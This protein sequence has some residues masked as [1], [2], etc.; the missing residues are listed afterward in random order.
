[1]KVFITSGPIEQG[2]MFVDAVLEVKR[3]KLFPFLAGREA[4]RN[5]ICRLFTEYLAPR[6]KDKLIIRFEDECEECGNVM[7][8][9]GYSHEFLRCHNPRCEDGQP[10]R[11]HLHLIMAEMPPLD[12]GKELAGDWYNR[13]REVWRTRYGK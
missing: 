13:M 3:P 6:K 9:G 7:D 10:P 12:D 11:V 4:E 1:V 5:Q 8:D 2:K